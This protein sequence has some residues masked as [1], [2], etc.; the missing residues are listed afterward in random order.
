MSAFAKEFLRTITRKP[1]RFLA[2]MAI[3]ALGAGFY[4]GLRMTAPDMNLAL[5]TYLDATNTYDIRVVSTLGLTDDDLE[6]LREV[7]GVSQVAGAFE[8]DAEAA[9]NGTDYTMRFHS[10]PEGLVEGDEA[11]INQIVLTEG[12]WP[13]KNGECV[14]CADRV[15]DAPFG[16]GDTITVNAH[17]GNAGSFLEE[18]EYNVVGLAVL[19]IA[20]QLGH[21][22]DRLGAGP[23][24]RLRARKRLQA[25]G[26]L[27]RGVHHGRGRQGRVRRRPCVLGSGQPCERRHQRNCR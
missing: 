27:H 16:V 25:H 18:R 24:I 14:I 21:E 22:L 3:V 17:V 1:G 15:M 10:L 6:A 4:A 12:E 7:D 20:S 9:M 11:C 13:S 8:C 5:D 23:A 26:A 2:L 19:R